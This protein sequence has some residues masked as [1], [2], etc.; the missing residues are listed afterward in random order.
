MY[1]KGVLHILSGGL[2]STVL[3]YWLLAQNYKVT[4]AITYFYGQ[5]HRKEVGK[6]RST[7]DFIK[8]S[9]EVEIPHY[10]LDISAIGTLLS[11][12]ALTGNID[13]PEGHY[14]EES[15]KL[16]VVPNR[17]M[18]FLAIAAMKAINDKNNLSLGIHAGDHAIYPDCREVFTK[19]FVETVRL[20]N[21]EAEGFDLL[22]PFLHKSK[23]EIV[24]TG[25]EAARKLNIEP[26][27]IFSRTWT[28]YK[29]EGKACGK[30]GACIERLEAFEYAKWKD[31]ICYE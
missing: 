12:S 28:C 29:G 30:C 25:I 24:V 7:I 23:G 21:W 14:E 4:G 2:D 5:R 19:A 1:P 16:T 17:N 20:G 8:S 10:V 18:A 11:S 3:L 22:T 26:D 13:V 27:E 15:M 31:P 9:L 6:A